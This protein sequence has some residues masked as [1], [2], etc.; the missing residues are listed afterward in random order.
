LADVRPNG[1]ARLD[2]LARFLQDVADVDAETA[3]IEDAD[4]VWILR[5]LSLRV[6][7]TPRFR[8]TVT[9]ATWCSG[10]GARWAERRTDVARDGDAAP[11][12]EA[13]ALWVH[14]DRATGR[15]KPL[16]DGFE[17]VWGE[18]SRTRRVRAR[19]HHAGP[20]AGVHTRAWPVRATDFDVVGHVNNAAYW[21]AVEDE[22]ARRGIGHVTSAVIEFGGGIEPDEPVELA[23]ADVEGGFM[24]WFLVGDEA[25]A[26][27]SVHSRT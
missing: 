20:P 7:R 11:C 16:P 27:A 3:A 1:R 22:I 24:C 26:S 25:R 12:V 6:T 2:A 23:V 9:L 18:A 10:T 5:R 13:A 8:D 4:S 14:V 17:R 19:L 15:P 21:A